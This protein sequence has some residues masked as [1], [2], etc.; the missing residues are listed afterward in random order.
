[1]VIWNLCMYI[2][3]S[4]MG[5]D[6]PFGP[7]SVI[8]DSSAFAPLMNFM[9]ENMTY[10]EDIYGWFVGAGQV[11][12]NLFCLIAFCRQASRL[13]E[14]V[15]MEMW[16]ELFIK[17]VLGNVLML[18]G[19]NIIRA[20]LN[21]ASSTSS[22]FLNISNVDIVTSNIDLGAVLGYVLIGIF[23]LI[24]SVICGIMIVV[25]VAKRIINIY[26]LTC[27]MPV[28]TPGMDSGMMT[29]QMT[30][31]PFAPRSCAASMV[32]SSIFV[33]TE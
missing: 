27:V 6:F 25:T 17:V 23:F 28:A 18:E 11:L 3:C 33:M 24:G 12:L 15:T 20:F 5:Y 31:Q 10:V 30:C 1:M 2:T 7:D 8:S 19:L 16:I 26:L 4:L 29:R 9:N 32:R 13:R 21:V 22:V 14:N